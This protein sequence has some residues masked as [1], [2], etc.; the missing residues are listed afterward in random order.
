MSSTP[1]PISFT[2]ITKDAPQATFEAI[3][4]LV[5]RRIYQKGDEVVIVDTSRYDD[6]QSPELPQL[7]V[8]LDIDFSITY[9]PELVRDF[10]PWIEKWVPDQLEEFKS[11]YP[12][13][14]LLWDF[15][16]ARELSRAKAKHPICFWLDSDDVFFG[17]GAK[18][19]QAIEKIMGGDEPKADAVFLDYRYTFGE[20]GACTTNLRRERAFF[21]DRYH[22]VGRCH[23]TAIPIPG[24]TPPP[25]PVGFVE[26]V[27]ASI[28]HTE[29]RKPAGV[30]DLRNYVIL[31]YEYENAKRLDPRTVFYLAN[32]ARGLR[33]LTEADR[34]YKEFDQL[35]GSADDRYAAFYYRGTMYLDPS[36]QRPHEARDCFLE[37]IHLL[38]HDPRGYFALARCYAA[39]YRYDQSLYW[40][41]RGCE[42]P[43]PKHQVF[44]FDPT[45]VTYHP[46]VLAAYCAA[47]IKNPQ[48]A[49]AAAERAARARP[50]APE[51]K[52]L[53][54]SVR[55]FLSGAQLRNSIGT[56][57]SA[58]QHGGPHA[59]DAA[60]KL[61]E[62]FAAVPHELEEVGI[63]ADEDPDPREPRPNFAIFCGP[64]PEAWGPANR[65]TGIGGSE[66]MVIMLSEQ[67][68]K[69]GP[70]NVTVYANVPHDQRGVY[71][72]GVRW[73]HWSEFDRQLQ[74]DVVVF[75]RA[76]GAVNMSCRTRKR[77]VWCHDVQDPSLYNE[78]NLPLIDKVQLQSQF[79]A[80]P[81]LK[82]VDK[83]QLWIA[84]NAIEWY[85][86]KDVPRRD[87]KQIV[88]SS[89]PDRGLL[90][91]LEIF[92]RAKAIDPDL[93]FVAC[94]GFTP[95]TRKAFAGNQHRHL[96]DVDREMNVDVYEREINKL[97]DETGA[98]ML[99]RVGFERLASVML[100]SGIWLYP[101][102]FWEISC[103][104]AM[105]AQAAG[106]VPV[107][108]RTAAL[109]ETLL[110]E[111]EKLA[112]PL[113]PPQGTE[114]WFDAAATAVV[115]AGRVAA[116]DPRRTALAAAAWKAFNVVD[117]AKQW[118]GV[119]APE[120]VIA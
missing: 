99:H 12:D 59:Q 117:L 105:E 86:E 93:S 83:D 13:P 64:T 61:C 80:K 89:S 55:S 48:L 91:A 43:L 24:I 92:K 119:L 17:E 8:P 71:T 32:A 74:R 85:A 101:T 87:P 68:Q 107:A 95:F 79:H 26:D 28:D 39:L 96:P 75:W 27:Q 69:L 58:F 54:D 45:H 16:E 11:H 6:D 63:A 19:R 110:P 31:R 103:M 33:R 70:W 35:S 67:L 108:T 44:S 111:A 56:L 72:H 60:R 20:D 102:R 120:K 106:L 5:D 97:I 36:V 22:W 66:R 51:T 14:H 109:Q 2:L 7:L 76:P 90:T 114:D 29:H 77:V 23:E 37:C 41:N 116:C 73:C 98:N 100:G 34:L 81:L 47:E 57:L 15:S 118:I 46:H 42:L 113:P 30:S 84:R 40:Y 94:Y 62:E 9:A 115:R 112:P 21:R 104:G 78:T 82:V 50:D 65:E 4:S 52:I 3:K 1:T 53:V 18:L 49:Q 10:T 25:R 38:P 88:Y